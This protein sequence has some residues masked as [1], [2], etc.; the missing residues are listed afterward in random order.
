MIQRLYSFIL[1]LLTILISINAQVSKAILNSTRPIPR[2][3]LF[4]THLSLSPSLLSVLSSILLS[5]RICKHSNHSSHDWYR[6][7]NLWFISKWFM[8]NLFNST[9]SRWFNSSSRLCNSNFH[10]YKTKWRFT[11][12]S[13]FNFFYWKSDSSR[14]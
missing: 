12:N 11:F 7:W 14:E 9:N 5:G 6:R 2:H 13:I 1:L 4:F 3:S 8:P 10:R